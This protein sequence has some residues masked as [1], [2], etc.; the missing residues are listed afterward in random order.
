[1]KQYCRTGCLTCQ[2]GADHPPMCMQ[3][4]PLMPLSIWGS[5]TVLD[6]TSLACAD[7]APECM[8]ALPC[9]VNRVRSMPQRPGV[10]ALWGEDGQVQVSV[11]L[12]PGCSLRAVPLGWG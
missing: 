1:M 3:V 9:A 7:A 6:W 4:L 5:S 8:Q 2:A 10:T 12:Q 11:V